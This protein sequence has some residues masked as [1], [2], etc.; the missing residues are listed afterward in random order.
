MK[1]ELYNILDKGICIVISEIKPKD[2]ERLY[3]IKT[4]YPYLGLQPNSNEVFS[5]IG[6]IADEIRIGHKI[7]GIKEI[8]SQTG[9]GLKESKNYID[10]YFDGTDHIRSA[11]RFIEDH[12]PDVPDF[13]DSD[14]MVL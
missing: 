13:I 4:T 14:E 11:Q 3:G 9:W 6:K 1:A 12:V 2:F 8:R 7:A 10:K 5:N